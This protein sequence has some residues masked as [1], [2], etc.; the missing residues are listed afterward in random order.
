MSMRT[1]FS[2]VDGDAVHGR[3]GAAED[4]LIRRVRAAV[5][6]Q[7][8]PARPAARETGD[9]ELDAELRKLASARP[10]PVDA[11]ESIER[12]LRG[13]ARSDD[14]ADEGLTGFVVARTLVEAVGGEPVLTDFEVKDFFWNELQE[15][16]ADALGADAALVQAITEGRPLFGGS[17]GGECRYALLSPQETRRLRDALRR[18]ADTAPAGSEYEDVLLDEDDGAIACLSRI[19]EAGRWL[20]A[21]TT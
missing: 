1:T 8:Q 17:I 13:G 7:V 19:I 9:A 20:W 6:E 10:S 14:L 3:I 18:A 16:A 21:E 5:E 2:G 12:R 11:L 15:E 4:D